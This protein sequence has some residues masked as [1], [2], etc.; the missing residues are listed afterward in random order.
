[1]PTFVLN[2]CVDKFGQSCVRNWEKGLFVLQW[3]GSRLEQGLGKPV[4]VMV[5]TCFQVLMYVLKSDQ[6]KNMCVL[7]CQCGFV[8]VFPSTFPKT[9]PLSWSNLLA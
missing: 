3:L 4:L 9:C 2:I 6:S 5:K 7:C 8:H 1:M